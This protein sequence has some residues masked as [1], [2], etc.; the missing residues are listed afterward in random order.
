MFQ[1]IRAQTPPAGTVYIVLSLTLG[2]QSC[3]RGPYTSNCSQNIT[4][5]GPTTLPLR[6]MSERFDI[7]CTILA[8]DGVSYIWVFLSARVVLMLL[9]YC[10][11]MY[12]AI[13]RNLRVYHIVHLCIPLLTFPSSVGDTSHQLPYHWTKDSLAIDNYSTERFCRPQITIGLPLSIPALET[14]ILKLW[15][16]NSVTLADTLRNCG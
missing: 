1:H 16:A 13:T 6:T 2:S 4:G 8:L 7:L 12:I 11:H 15:I 3:G 5:Y 14:T 9:Y 10:E